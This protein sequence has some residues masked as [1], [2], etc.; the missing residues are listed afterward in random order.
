M[1]HRKTTLKHT[2]KHNCIVRCK[3]WIL[4]ET[5][6]ASSDPSCDMLLSLDSISEPWYPLYILLSMLMS[7][8]SSL[9]S[10][11]ASSSRPALDRYGNSISSHATQRTHSYHIL[12]TCRVRSHVRSVRGAMHASA[13]RAAKPENG[14]RTQPRAMHAH[15]HTS[16]LLHTP[17]LTPH[18]QISVRLFTGARRIV[19]RDEKLLSANPR[20]SNSPFIC[21]YL[22]AND[23][24]SRQL[25][26]DWN[27][28]AASNK[29][30]ESACNC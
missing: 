13:E 21:Y 3:L 19:E 28:L 22:G 7:S 17:P 2:T 15:T 8:L 27:K 11:T 10:A 16:A 29:E 5:L 20:N 14:A 23:S 12:V 9:S 18:P 6:T 30:G 25:S 1:N 24:N 26:Q 4:V